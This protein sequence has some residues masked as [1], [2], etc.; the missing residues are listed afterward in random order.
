M[1]PTCFL[2]KKHQNPPQPLD[3]LLY[4]KE[5]R[6]DTLACVLQLSVWEVSLDSSEAAETSEEWR[7][8][9]TVSKFKRKSVYIT[10][11]VCFLH[12]LI[13]SIPDQSKAELCYSFLFRPLT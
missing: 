13:L 12:L 7:S 5:L 9:K 3:L 11:S 1:A 8:E 6:L 10:T 2:H 4:R